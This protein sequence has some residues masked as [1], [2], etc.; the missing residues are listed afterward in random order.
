MKKR[1][2]EM[3]DCSG[4]KWFIDERSESLEYVRRQS[5]RSLLWPFCSNN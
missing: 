5:L 2:E 3:I 4:F 1:I